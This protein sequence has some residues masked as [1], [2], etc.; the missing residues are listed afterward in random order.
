MLEELKKM[1]C[2][3]VSADESEIDENT[4]LRSELAMSSLD[5][6]NLAVEVEE[7]Y[8]IELPNEDISGITTLGDLMKYISVKK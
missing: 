3:Y 5:L 8:N 7:T 6:I 2:N 4:N 1:I